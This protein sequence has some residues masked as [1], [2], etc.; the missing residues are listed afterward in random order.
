AKSIQQRA[1]L[2]QAE[3][4]AEDARRRLGLLRQGTASAT[5]AAAVLGQLQ[6]EVAALDN[7]LT[8]VLPTEI[9]QKTR[10]LE[11][12]EREAAE[13]QRSREDVQEMEQLEYQLRRENEQTRQQ[14]EKA[15][16]DRPDTNLNML[17]QPAALAAKKRAEKEGE[18]ERLQEER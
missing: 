8:Q 15:L 9:G 17:R 1:Q 13:P 2:H 12:L 3:T 18:W 10:K 5:T 16:A 14:I 7:K 11:Q 6:R 4:R